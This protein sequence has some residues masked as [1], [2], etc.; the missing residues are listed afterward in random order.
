DLKEFLGQFI[1]LKP[2][3]VLDESGRVVGHHDGAIL[4]TIGERHGFTLTTQTPNEQPHYVIARDIKNN[5]ITV[6][7]KLMKEK[8]AFIL[9]LEQINWLGDKPKEDKTYQARIR[10]RG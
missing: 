6:S 2:G 8:E 7:K 10:H 4:Y 5:T 1:K 3:K 9:E